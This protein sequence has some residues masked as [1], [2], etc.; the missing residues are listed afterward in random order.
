MGSL[1]YGGLVAGKE[2]EKAIKGI[3]DKVDKPGATQTSQKVTQKPQR[4]HLAFPISF[5]KRNFPDTDHMDAAS[6]G[7]SA[8]H[9][10]SR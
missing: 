4:V 5:H 7:S 3:M 10:S 8:G 1:G 2:R 9:P 6:G